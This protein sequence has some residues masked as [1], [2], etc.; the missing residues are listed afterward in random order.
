[1]FFLFAIITGLLV[2]WKK[3]KPNFHLFRPKAKL[4]TIWTDAHTALGVIGFPFQFV[5]A[6][7]GTFLIFGAIAFAPPVASLLYDGNTREM[8][9]DLLPK[10]PDYPLEGKVV[11]FT[12]DIN[13]FVDKTKDTWSDFRIKSVKL[14]NYGDANMKVAVLGH[15]TYERSLTGQGK[16]VFD[17]AS[18]K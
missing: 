17:V 6:L 14:T 9:A 3:I 10:T 7:T 18:K 16:L 13:Y 15:P 4:K 11:N 12:G 8:Y 2:H 1:F 5:F